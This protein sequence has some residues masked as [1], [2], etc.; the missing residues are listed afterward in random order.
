MPEEAHRSGGW[1]AKDLE[2]VP[3]AWSLKGEELPGPQG[4]SVTCSNSS[5]CR[6]GPRRPLR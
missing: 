4:Q 2:F 1:V 5:T 6:S 3:E